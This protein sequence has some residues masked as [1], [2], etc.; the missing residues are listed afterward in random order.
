M[1]SFQDTGCCNAL[2]SAEKALQE[3]IEQ[4]SRADRKKKFCSPPTPHTNIYYCFV[5]LSSGDKS[6][7]PRIA[8]HLVQ[9]PVHEETGHG[10]VK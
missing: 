7:I 9:A 2:G 3:A 1:S 5:R 4:V 8:D 6:R 10:Q